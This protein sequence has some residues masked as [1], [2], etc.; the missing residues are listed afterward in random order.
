MCATLPNVPHG[1]SLRTQVPYLIVIN[2]TVFTDYE[3]RY[4]DG[5][6][7]KV[8]GHVGCRVLTPLLDGTKVP[9]SGAHPGPSGLQ[10]CD[11]VR[12]DALL[13]Q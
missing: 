12:G 11:G 7:I 10:P 3:H 8:R 1:V 9:Y 4:D 6:G 5:Y 2:T 13:T